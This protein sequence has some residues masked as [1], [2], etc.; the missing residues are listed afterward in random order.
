MDRHAF[1][2]IRQSFNFSCYQWG[3]ALGYGG[4]HD[5]IR[6]TIERYEKGEREVPPIVAR[7][8]S[9]YYEHGIPDEF[10]PHS[11]NFGV[12]LHE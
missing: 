12:K 2:A 3:I 5:N 6:K 11:E 8:A 4:K 9:M 1:K 7:L 10:D